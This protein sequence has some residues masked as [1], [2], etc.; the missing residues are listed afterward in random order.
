MMGN[1]H[2]NTSLLSR[3][4]PAR[5]H[6]NKVSH[7]FFYN[8]FFLREMQFRSGRSYSIY[9][10][11][12]DLCSRSTC[13]RTSNAQPLGSTLFG[14][15]R[16]F[17]MIGCNLTFLCNLLHAQTGS[18]QIPLTIPTILHFFCLIDLISSSEYL[19]NFTHPALTLEEDLSM[20]DLKRTE[21][22]WT[23]GLLY[24]H[25]LTFPNQ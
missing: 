25:T 12:T 11:T 24:M 15:R 17:R 23:P 16:F 7:I 14:G 22:E 1:L 18:N 3:F 2:F 8:T 6:N 13:P 10:A 20:I 21:K 4:T 9:S 19:F 5:K